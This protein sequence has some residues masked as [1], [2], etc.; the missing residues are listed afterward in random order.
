MVFKLFD[1]KTGSGISVNEQLAEELPKPI[2]KIFKRRKVYARLK[3]I[4][5]QQI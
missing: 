1:Q 2:I 5:G 4:F 3:K